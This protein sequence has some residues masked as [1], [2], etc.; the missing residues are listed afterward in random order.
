MGYASALA[1]ILFAILMIFTYFQFKSQSSWVHY[2][3][4]NV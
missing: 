4:G 1:W 3:G 2:E